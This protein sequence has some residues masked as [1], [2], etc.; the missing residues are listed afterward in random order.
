MSKLVY[1]WGINDADYS[2]NPIVNGKRLIC[3]FYAIW[4]GVLGRCLSDRVKAKNKS[5]E[6]CNVHEDWKYF[7]KF[8]SW[9]EPLF[10]EGYQL[11]KD[12]LVIGNSLYGPE[13]CAFVLRYINNLVMNVNNTSRFSKYGNSNL[14]LG[15]TYKQ[16]S[17]DMLCELS[18]P[19]E[20]RCSASILDYKKDP[21]LG[22]FSSA[23]DAHKMWQ[24]RKSEVIQS[25]TNIYALTE[26]KEEKI[27][28]ALYRKADKLIF[29]IENSLITSFI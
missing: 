3:P 7:S 29:E 12:I 21:S 15:V 4:N 8:K 26:C 13:T 24:L 6:K 18:K 22:F 28:E 20:A 10:V 2:V 23:I 9:A 17:S 19:F 25:V 14:P 1:G 16:K 11:D 27:T 5:Y